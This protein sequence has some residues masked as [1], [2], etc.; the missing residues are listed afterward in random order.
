MIF[1][2][3][4]NSVLCILIIG[5]LVILLWL[6]LQRLSNNHV[7]VFGLAVCT[8]LPNARLILNQTSLNFS[9]AHFFV[10][11]VVVLDSS[12]LPTSYTPIAAVMHP[13]HVLVTTKNKKLKA[14]GFYWN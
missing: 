5:S 6:C 12:T 2:K 9:N 14:T 8:Y 10:V 4:E 11:N 13:L 1:E 7:H 3:T